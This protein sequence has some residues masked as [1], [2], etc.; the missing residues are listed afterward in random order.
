MKDVF[1]RAEKG[2]SYSSPKNAEGPSTPVQHP[3]KTGGLS[4]P[5]PRRFKPLPNRRPPSE[6]EATIACIKQPGSPSKIARPRTLKTTS[7][8]TDGAQEAPFLSYSPAPSR[9]KARNAPVPSHTPRRLR[10]R[11]PCQPSQLQ[12]PLTV[13]KE[14]MSRGGEPFPR[15]PPASLPPIP[16][17]KSPQKLTP[18]PFIP[19]NRTAVPF[20]PGSQLPARTKSR[21]LIPSSP[22][23][24]LREPRCHPFRAQLATPCPHKKP[25]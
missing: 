4:Q 18:Y 20:A 1:P 14:G 16:P 3:R 11:R 7:T 9:Q 19:R 17:T 2:C 12:G 10:G 25:A 15:S 6:K 21:P 22:Q 13:Q 5:R 24:A 8:E 23:A